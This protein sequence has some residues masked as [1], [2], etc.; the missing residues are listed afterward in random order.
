[1]EK[2]VYIKLQTN[3]EMRTEISVSLHFHKHICVCARLI[4]QVMENPRRR[5]LE[6]LVSIYRK[7][8][9]ATNGQTVSS[10]RNCCIFWS[11][12]VR[13]TLWARKR[14]IPQKKKSFCFDRQ[15]GCCLKF[16]LRLQVRHAILQTITLSP[17]I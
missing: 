11:E 16:K 10:F 9:H 5:A 13:E 4:Y 14:W 12:T 17:A 7:Q 8:V 6:D 1:M 15:T 3:S 2:N